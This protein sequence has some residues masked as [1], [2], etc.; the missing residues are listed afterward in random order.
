M[1][2]HFEPLIFLS[3]SLKMAIV[4]SGKNEKAAFSFYCLKQW[5]CQHELSSIHAVFSILYFFELFGFTEHI[6]ELRLKKKIT[7]IWQIFN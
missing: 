6:T 5:F 4:R 2:V 1:V 7:E 3:V